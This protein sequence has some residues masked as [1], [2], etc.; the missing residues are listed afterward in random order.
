ML[1]FGCL[2]R[3]AASAAA[4]MRARQGGRPAASEGLRRTAIPQCCR[5]ARAAGFQPIC[6][7]LEALGLRREKRL[8]RPPDCPGDYPGDKPS[9]HPWS[10]SDRCT[11][12]RLEG[13]LRHHHLDSLVHGL[14]SHL[15]CSGSGRNRDHLAVRPAGSLPRCPA[16]SRGHSCPCGSGDHVARSPA[17]YALNTLPGR[18]SGRASGRSQRSRPHGVACRAR[19]AICVICGFSPPRPHFGVLL[20][21]NHLPAHLCPFVVPQFRFRNSALWYLVSEFCFIR[22]RHWTT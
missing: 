18:S 1:R 7:K 19:P 6:L 10:C 4:F 2:K 14:I 16:H 8:P 13:S 20:G 3:R 15:V 17:H 12:H 22:V 9:N 21:P 5:M 11:V